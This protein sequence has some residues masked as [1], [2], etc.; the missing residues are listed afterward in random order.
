MMA[1]VIP[2]MMYQGMTRDWLAACFAGSLCLFF[3]NLWLC[4][5][6]LL[7]A[8]VIELVFLPCWTSAQLYNRYNRMNS[9]V[10][11]TW[12]DFA[13]VL[14]QFFTGIATMYLYAWLKVDL[15]ARVREEHIKLEQGQL[16]FPRQTDSIVAQP[17]GCKLWDK[18]KED[19]VARY[20]NIHEIDI[21]ANILC[22]NCKNRIDFIGE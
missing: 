12:W 18:K 17:C 21:R 7:S 14:A 16:S 13:V 11:T 15:E 8:F 9:T 1:G 22:P 19:I 3:G 20:N 4:K 10:F 5:E 2:P 6:M